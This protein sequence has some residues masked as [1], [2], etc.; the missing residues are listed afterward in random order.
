MKELLYGIPEAPG[1]CPRV[2]AWRTTRAAHHS[3]RPPVASD[4]F[5]YYIHRGDVYNS[6]QYL[7]SDIVDDM[8]IK[9]GIGVIGD[10]Y[11][12][13]WCDVAGGDSSS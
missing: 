8:V 12:I 1:T 6:D 2:Y 7:R 11:G 9:G 10:V 3:I 4:T 13:R 5:N